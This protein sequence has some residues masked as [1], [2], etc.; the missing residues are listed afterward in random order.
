[1]APVGGPSVCN[2]DA[3]RGRPS[4]TI[5]ARLLP[6]MTQSSPGDTV[7]V[8]APS[9][10][11]AE[12]ELTIADGKGGAALVARRRNYNFNVELK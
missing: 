10:T 7:D 5:L 6:M 8:K 2:G 1:M 11:A 3:N 12:G 9:A 4:P